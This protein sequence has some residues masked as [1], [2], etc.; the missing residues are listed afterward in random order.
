MRSAEA[1]ANILKN[2]L[3][4]ILEAAGGASFEDIRLDDGVKA[5]ILADPLFT[6]EI[7]S[8]D[9]FCVKANPTDI[10]ISILR[11][12]YH[13]F[14]RAERQWLSANSLAADSDHIA[15]TVVSA[16]YCAFFC[17]IEILRILGRFPLSLSQAEATL[18]ARRAVGAHKQDF[19]SK[20]H[21]NFVGS[22][23]GDFSEITFKAS[24]DRPHQFAWQ[25]LSSTAF[26]YF[27]KKTGDWVE[28]G[29]FKNI[30]IGKKGWEN[31]S[32][33]R[34]RWNYRDSTYFGALGRKSSQPFLKLLQD[35]SSAS[36]W[37]KDRPKVTSEVDSIASLAALGQF[38]FGAVK[39]A[40]QIGFP[41]QNN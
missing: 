18:F 16:Y 35:R 8:E 11:D 32:D 38:L 20:G 19:L 3:D 21:R 17:A 6:I 13:G 28:L 10:C 36:A 27:P 31:P 29:K 5:R 24:G 1:L 4:S 25:Q 41:D 30:C 23:S 34:N 2:A 9:A 15:W 22:P 40:Y 39:E 14:L 12:Y 26:S 7:V 37:I 33:I